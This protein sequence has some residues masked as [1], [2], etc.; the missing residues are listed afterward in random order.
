MVCPA[1]RFGVPTLNL[2][3]LRRGDGTTGDPSNCAR[4]RALREGV[5]IVEAVDRNGLLGDSCC[6]RHFAAL[7]RKSL[8]VKSHNV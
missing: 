3:G 8:Y 1:L 2:R 7:N 5:K 4:K 6:P